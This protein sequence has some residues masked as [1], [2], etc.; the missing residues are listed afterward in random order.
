MY[1]STGSSG[2]CCK[3]RNE[4][5]GPR[6]CGNM[7]GNYVTISLLINVLIHRRINIANN[8][9]GSSSPSSSTL[10]EKIKKQNCTLFANR[11]KNYITLPHPREITCE[12][13][14]TMGP[15][16]TFTGKYIPRHPS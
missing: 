2:W 13:A 8:N 9:N 11:N 4:T 15:C 5:L 1:L 6:K 7:S 12:Q 10:I 3:H 16:N 14:E